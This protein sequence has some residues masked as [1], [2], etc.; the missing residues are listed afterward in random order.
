LTHVQISDMAMTAQVK[1]C[2]S[3]LITKQRR[4]AEVATMP[5]F[6]GGLTSSVGRL[7]WEA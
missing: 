4:K 5:R 6:A 7:S 2:S 1:S 3:T